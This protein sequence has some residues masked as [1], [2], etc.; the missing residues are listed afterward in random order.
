[1]AVKHCCAVLNANYINLE[2]T[3]GTIF[4]PALLIVCVQI[5]WILHHNGN[6]KAERAEHEA[7]LINICATSFLSQV[8]AV[9]S[10]HNGKKET[11]QELPLCKNI[12]K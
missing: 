7:V 3:K 6:R 1:M 12:V 5:C 8:P 2:R 10:C 9:E 4:F 11:I